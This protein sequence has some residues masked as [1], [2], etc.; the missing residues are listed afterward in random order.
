MAKRLVKERIFTTPPP[1]LPKVKLEKRIMKERVNLP[2]PTDKEE[3]KM[4]IEK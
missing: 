1:I 3:V 4:K 2:L